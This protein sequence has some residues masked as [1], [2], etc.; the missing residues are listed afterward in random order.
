[1]NAVG[2]VAGADD[3][4]EEEDGDDDGND[5]VGD[6]VNEVFSCLQV[7]FCKRDREG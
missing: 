4:D 7:A 1:M 3:Y 5:N 2:D 6:G